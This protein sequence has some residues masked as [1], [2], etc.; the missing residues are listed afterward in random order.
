MFVN[1]AG[2]LL[3]RITQFSIL[4]H[5]NVLD[6]LASASHNVSRLGIAPE[7]GLVRAVSKK[8]QLIRLYHITKTKGHRNIAQIAAE[9]QMQMHRDRVY[10]LCKKAEIVRKWCFKSKTSASEILKSI[11][12]NPDWTL[13]QHANKMGV[14]KQYVHSVK[15]RHEGNSE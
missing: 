6:E 2:R 10:Q 12:D 1:V 7:H 11:E 14:T 5:S 4:L 3:I 9:M 13:Q 8:N 15:S